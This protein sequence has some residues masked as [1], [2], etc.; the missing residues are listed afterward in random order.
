MGL[1]PSYGV[2]ARALTAL[3]LS[4]TFSALLL[5]C[6]SDGTPT[7]PIGSSGAPA[8]GGAARL[9][10]REI[11]TAKRRSSGPPRLC[12][13]PIVRACVERARSG[14]QS[15]PVHYSTP[16]V[17]AGFVGRATGNGVSALS[18]AVQGAR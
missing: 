5:N 9:L 2:A 4:L 16:V 17:R 6:S 15:T 14:V 10:G 11:N 7:K 18:P 12:F 3:W 13:D 1:E 8:S